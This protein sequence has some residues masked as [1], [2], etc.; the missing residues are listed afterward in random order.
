MSYTTRIIS[1]Q[2]EASCIIYRIL[3]RYDESIQ[4]IRGLKKLFSPKM[5]TEQI[6]TKMKRDQNFQ[7]RIKL[8]YKFYPY[9]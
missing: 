6:I 8:N 2:I 3:N 1:Y 7:N 9:S 4:Q 5:P